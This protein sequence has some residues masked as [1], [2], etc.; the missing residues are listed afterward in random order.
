MNIPAAY[1]SGVR[2]D[3]LALL[4]GSP[5]RTILEIGGGEFHTLLSFAESGRELWAV[6]VREPESALDH[7]VLGS[8]TDPNVA[9]K[10][11]DGAFDLIIANDVLEHVEDT[12]AFIK[13]VV[14]KLSSGGQLLL[15]VP[16][17]RQL[18][19]A[20]HVFIRGTFPRESAGLFDETHVRWFCRDDVSR[21]F[22]EGGLK[23][24]KSRSVGRLVPAALEPTLIG[25]FL[26][27]QN[28]FLFYRP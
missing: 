8:I 20:Y 3:V 9:A 24:R 18:R 12:R 5:G 16:N 2:S 10:L 4:D 21:L 1:Y 6:D 15:S 11:P 13:I 17:A 23:I 28:L 26:G 7:F 25:Q 27:L 14:Q 22:S 19:L